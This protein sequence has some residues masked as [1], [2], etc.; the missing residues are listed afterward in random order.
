LLRVVV[1]FVRVATVFGGLGADDLTPAFRK[2]G[3]ASHR[4]SF[5]REF[6]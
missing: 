3:G 5:V 2:P 1:T 6:Q 4:V